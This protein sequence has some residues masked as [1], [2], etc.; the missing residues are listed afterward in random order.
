MTVWS[1]NHTLSW[2]HAVSFFKSSIKDI[3]YNPQLPFTDRV[4]DLDAAD[5]YVKAGNKR[6]RQLRHDSARCFFCRA[7]V[8][9]EEMGVDRKPITLDHPNL[10]VE[11]IETLEISEKIRRGMLDCLHDVLIP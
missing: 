4:R 8:Q 3:S 6:G 5:F 7:D 1:A 2:L 10:L 11:T 9:T